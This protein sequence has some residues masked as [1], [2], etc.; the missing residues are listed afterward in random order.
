MEAH[1]ES[2]ADNPRERTQIGDPAH[3]TSEFGLRIDYVLPSRS[4]PMRAAGVSWPP[5]HDPGA[6]LVEV[7]DH[8]LVW[9]DVGSP[10]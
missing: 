6:A 2:N 7:S 8:R 5:P 4:L 1:D 10:E 9:I 3:D